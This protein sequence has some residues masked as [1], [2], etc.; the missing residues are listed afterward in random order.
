[1]GPSTLASRQ[2]QAILPFVTRYDLGITATF[3]DAKDYAARLNNEEAFDHK[4]WHLPTK[5]A[6]NALFNN[7]AAIGGF[8]ERDYHALGWYWSATPNFKWAAWCQRFSDGAQGY[9]DKV[10]RS[11]V[12]CVR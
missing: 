9:Y 8:N 11:S 1:M 5:A 3:N 4:D 6:L 7:R 12:R 10:F 2:I